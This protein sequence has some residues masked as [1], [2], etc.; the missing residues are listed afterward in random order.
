MQRKTGLG[1]N[2]GTKENSKMAEAK[3]S[4]KQREASK[5]NW[6]KFCYKLHKEQ[7]ML[8]KVIC[9]KTQTRKKSRTVYNTQKTAEVLKRLTSSLKC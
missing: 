9:L 2:N 4:T 3:I 8:M 1:G 7:Q 6:S 5:Q